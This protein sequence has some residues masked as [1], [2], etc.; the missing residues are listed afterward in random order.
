VDPDGT[1]VC[2]RA[3]EDWVFDR[4]RIGIEYVEEMLEKNPVLIHHLKRDI[5]EKHINTPG[6]IFLAR[7]M[8]NRLYRVGILGLADDEGQNVGSFFITFAYNCV[9]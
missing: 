9:D 1:Y 7:Y 3:D 5:K 2:V 8:D 4:I 6:Y